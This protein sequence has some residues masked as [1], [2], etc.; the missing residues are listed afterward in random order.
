VQMRNALAVGGWCLV[1]A[2][3]ECGNY[4][5]PHDTGP[6]VTTCD[7]AVAYVV[8]HGCHGNCG[9]GV[10]CTIPAEGCRSCLSPGV[11]VLLVCGAAGVGSGLRVEIVDG[12]VCD[13][14]ASTAPDGG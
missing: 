5:V 10:Y 3:T 4:G 13:V 7:E 1:V 14:D 2:F 9:F 6:I 11:P 12:G 8:E